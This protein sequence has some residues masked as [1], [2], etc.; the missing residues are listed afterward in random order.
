MKWVKEWKV[1]SAPLRNH[2]HTLGYYAIQIVMCS[3][4][5]LTSAPDRAQT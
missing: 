5:E 1:R 2:Q 4:L 3:D